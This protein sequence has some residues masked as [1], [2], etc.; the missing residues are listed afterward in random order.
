[1]KFFNRI[2]LIAVNLF[3]PLMLL[4]GQTINV[5]SELYKLIQE[6][7]YS[8]AEVRALSFERV[9]PNLVAWLKLKQ[10]NFVAGVELLEKS[11]KS[12]STNQVEVLLSSIAILAEVSTEDALRMAERYLAMAEWR[13]EEKLKASLVR[14][15]LKHGSQEDAIVI[16]EGLYKNKIAPPTL[17][18]DT[19]KLVDDLYTHGNS[20]QA[21]YFLEKIYDRVPETTIDPGYQLQWCHIVNGL[22]RSTEVLLKLD[23]IQTKS[24][25]YFLANEGLFH[26]ARAMS[27]RGIGDH[28]R[29][30]SEWQLVTNLAIKNHRFDSD[31][32]FAAHELEQI[33]QFETILK[34]VSKKT[35]GENKKYKIIIIYILIFTATLLPA[36]LCLKHKI[37]RW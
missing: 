24:P 8:E 21:L 36:I 20:V 4:I 28:A 23:Q 19:Y 16:M 2:Q 9:D 25:E 31:A 35:K 13:N 3:A 18:D 37:I 10:G 30:K 26:M 5:P 29:S 33:A 7:K 1:M 14:L 17:K 22:G 11:I 27:Y 12:A 32:R 34:G 15:R 6:E